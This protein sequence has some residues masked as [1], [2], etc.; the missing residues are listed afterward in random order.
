MTPSMVLYVTEVVLRSQ[1]NITITPLRRSRS[2]HHI[3]RTSYGFKLTP[4]IVRYT[5]SGSWLSVRRFSERLAYPRILSGPRRPF[6]EADSCTT[7]LLVLCLGPTQKYASRP[8]A[9]WPRD[10]DPTGTGRTDSSLNGPR[11]DTH[12]HVHQ[13]TP[14]TDGPLGCRPCPQL[15]A[16]GGN[17]V[18]QNEL[19]KID[20][21]FSRFRPV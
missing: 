11:Y 17:Y 19:R 1:E 2:F 5:F 15:L 10:G 3:V 6:A 12:Q 20:P 14:R 16:T 21:L 8:W 7:L 9:G 13:H 18:G 4:Y